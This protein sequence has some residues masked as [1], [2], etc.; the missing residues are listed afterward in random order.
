MFRN[1]FFVSERESYESEREFGFFSVSSFRIASVWV[2]MGGI[3]TQKSTQV[4][5]VP[6]QETGF[7]PEVGG[8]PPRRRISAQNGRISAH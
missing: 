6:A 3:Y 8:F 5:R 2:E 7:R 1:G 4:G